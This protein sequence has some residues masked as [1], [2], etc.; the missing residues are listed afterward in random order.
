MLSKSSIMEMHPRG[1]GFRAGGLGWLGGDPAGA[2]TC[3]LEMADAELRTR[4]EDPTVDPRL[5][6]RHRVR[7]R[8]VDVQVTL[9]DRAKAPRRVSLVRPGAGMT[10]SKLNF[11]ACSGSTTS[12][13]RNFI[14]CCSY[15]AILSRQKIYALLVEKKSSSSS[16]G[17]CL[18]LVGGST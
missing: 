7:H 14:L 2:T 17:D 9:H 15:R 13:L 12:S 16:S 11:T 1:L 4:A 10:G 5:A 18:T 3:S 6:V 8:V